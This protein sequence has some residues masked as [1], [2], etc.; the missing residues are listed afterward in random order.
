M[1]KHTILFLAANPSGTDRLALDR[2]ARAIQH[3]LERSGHRDCFQF[4]TRWAV[5]PLDLLRELRR[6]KPTVVHFSGHGQGGRSKARPGMRR[7]FGSGEGSLL[8]PGGAIDE[9]GHEQAGETGPG[10]GARAGL[11][12]VTHDGRPQLVTTQAIEQTFGAAGA[13]VR[14]VVLN[15]CYSDEQAEALLAHVDCVV[16]MTGSILDA[17]ARSFAIGFYGG[18][19]EREPVGA[20]HRQGR[21]AISLEGLPDGQLPRLRARAGV[22]PD[23]LV[24]ADR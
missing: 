14:L 5:E 22:D 17:A 16:G 12:F 19:G 10:S 9:G 11:Y 3:E 23:R 6:L 15:A 20:A 1:T 7:D 21:A 18:L 13:S 2:E 24:L 4:E 8:D